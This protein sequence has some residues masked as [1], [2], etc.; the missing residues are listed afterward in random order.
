MKTEEIGMLR[1]ASNIELPNIVVLPMQDMTVL[2]VMPGASIALKLV[3]AS[4]GQ[5]LR[6]I[7][8]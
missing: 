6:R 3:R 5:I 7:Q 2:T 4:T 1:T 8:V